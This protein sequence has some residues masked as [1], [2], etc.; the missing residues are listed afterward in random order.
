M[1]RRLPLA[2]S[3]VAPWPIPEL[4]GAS[5]E[6]VSV[7]PQ[8]AAV[9]GADRDEPNPRQM[10]EEQIAKGHT[11]GLERGLKEGREK[12]YTQGFA[13]GRRA[14]DQR[15][16]DQAHRLAGLIKR[17]GEPIRA[18]ERPVEEAV[19]GLGL[20]IA[21]QVI[22]AEVSQSRE[23]LLRLVR[24]AIAQV[25]IEMGAP[26][27]ILHPADLALLRELAP[28]I[29]GGGVELVAD[30][31]IDAGGCLVVADNANGPIKD[32]RW[33]QRNR[34]G[35]SQV[36]LTLAARWRSVMLALFD[37]EGE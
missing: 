6:A 37:S 22:G 14:A 17:L 7:K 15:V 4:D 34:D 21:R 28:E 8:V 35:S 30:E 1:T 18:L 13:E 16:A 36:D 24:E 25:P 3:A 11:E 20:E 26:K 31:S 33:Y 9:N 2:S 29:E 27:I 10:L 19:V 5:A 12:G 23:P 32:K